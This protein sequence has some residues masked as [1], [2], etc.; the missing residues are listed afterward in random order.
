MRDH[1]SRS[2]PTAW[3]AGVVMCLGT[4]IG[5]VSVA[6]GQ[7]NQDPQAVQ[8]QAALAPTDAAQQ[9]QTLPGLLPEPHF[10][11]AVMDRLANAFGGAN[12]PKDGFHPTFFSDD[13]PG[14]GLITIGAGYR[15]HFWDGQV[16]LDLST[17]VSQREYTSSV[18]R[19]ELPHLVDDHF[20]MG[21]EVL[22]QDW[23]QAI[24]F[25]VGPTSLEANRSQ[26]QLRASDIFA[27][28]S[29]HSR[30]AFDLRL[31][32]GELQPTV[33]PTAGWFNRGYPE[34]QDLFTDAS[35][36]GLTQQPGFWHGDVSV[37]VNTLNHP[38]HPTRG[39][40]IQVTAAEYRDRNLGQFS[41]QRY[42]GTVI[43]YIP[44]VAEA[45]T[46]AVRGSLVASETEGANQV[47]F[48]FLPSL[49]G[50]HALRGY[51]DFRFHDRDLAAVNVESRWAVWPHI[52]V[53]VFADEG[54]VAPALRSF[55]GANLLSSYG[56]GLRLHTRT[57]TV[58]RVD[59]GHSSEG[60]RFLVKTSNA[61][62]FSTLKHWTSVLPIF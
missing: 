59:I 5:Q 44:V 29:V 55:R 26:Y 38:G 1:S 11:G 13:V 21:A 33:S 2:R 35:A 52:D 37:T 9:P 31:R 14:A 45:W 50:E 7:T 23:T 12:A 6:Q 54:T 3:F 43:R 41:F 34:L 62:D 49:G 36:P 22:A 27:Y 28:A 47:P 42:E 25:G 17:A 61:L 48:Y 46:L 30:S 51:P 60:W 4:L 56:V 18:A 39:G 40:L 16:A 57:A 32:V 58:L 19:V 15:R 8:I 10:L 53:A 24:Y 20:V